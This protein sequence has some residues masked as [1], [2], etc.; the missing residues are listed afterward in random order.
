MKIWSRTDVVSD[1]GKRE[2]DCWGAAVNFMAWLQGRG[3]LPRLRFSHKSIC[4]ANVVM[5]L[6]YF[7]VYRKNKQKSNLEWNRFAL[8]GV[9]AA[10][11]HGESDAPDARC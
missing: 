1:A 3:T 7:C 4:G 11:E 6:Q 2:G 8:E 9:F 10:K 5:A